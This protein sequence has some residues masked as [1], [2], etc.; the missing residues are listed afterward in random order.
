MQKKAVASL[1]G[2]ST[3]AARGRL[4]M[5]LSQAQ[6]HSSKAANVEVLQSIINAYFIDDHQRCSKLCHVR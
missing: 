5:A 6:F 3:Q 2:K 4:F 1:L